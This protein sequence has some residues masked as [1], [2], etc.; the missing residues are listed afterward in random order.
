MVQARYMFFGNLGSMIMFVVYPTVMSISAL[1]V[2]DWVI[3][4]YWWVIAFI[5]YIYVRDIPS[6][7][8]AW[9]EAKINYCA[10]VS[11]VL[12]EKD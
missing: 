7:W 12:A 5:E 11:D 10:A 8:R 2:P 3:M 1:T 4:V 9:R 6:R